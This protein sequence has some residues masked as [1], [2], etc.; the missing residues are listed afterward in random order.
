MEVRYE[1]IL[2]SDMGTHRTPKESGKTSQ[3]PS[4]SGG[5]GKRKP[6]TLP[7]PFQGPTH[8]SPFFYLTF[9]CFKIEYDQNS[10]GFK[11]EESYELQ[12]ERKR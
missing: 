7:N 12:V 5:S 10:L 8:R 1:K 11:R 9:L 4:E 2:E 6:L 3:I